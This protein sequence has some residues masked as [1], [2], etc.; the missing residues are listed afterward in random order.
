MRF[1]YNISIWLYFF[2]ITV[3]SLFNDKA[4]LW[5]KGRKGIFDKIKIS[6][7]GNDNIIWFHCSSLGEF[8]QGRPLLE[9][10]KSEYPK[11][12]ILLTFFSPSGYEIRKNYEKTDYIFYLP[13]DTIS[14]AKKFVEL[15][16]P[17]I[18]VF[19]KY[20]F[21]FNYISEL[22]K[23]NI[24]IYSVSS[25]FRKNQYFFK[26]HGIWALQQ[27]K[28]IS[29]FFVQ[30]EKS[31]ELLGTL[32]IINVIV[33]GDTRF[34]RVYE[35]S[36]NVKKFPVIEAFRQNKKIL[37]AGSIWQKEE[38]FLIKLINE[39][40]F[41]IKYIIAP[42]LIKT[43]NIDNFISKI[44]LKA[45]KFSEATTENVVAPKVMLIDGIGFLSHLYQ[46]GTLALIGGGFG[47]GIHNI[48]EPATFGLPVFFGPNYTKFN[49]AKELLKCGG[50]YSI[51]DFQNLNEKLSCLLNNEEALKRNSYICL[52][53]VDNRKGAT[54]I[55]LKYIEKNI[56][57]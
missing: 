42:H 2:A 48:L 33:S 37:I 8:E 38:E 15:V 13:L 47:K 52:N 41:D 3:A 9:K 31:K 56:K 46:Y 30:D 34:D 40:E 24:P 4:K 57:F 55:I 5:L 32:G 50:A 35:I 39:S 29:C 27:L 22:H 53:Y 10:I 23:R 7:T 14:N 54:D 20:E 45:I 44:S 49:E 16:N 18:A 6:L 1:I 43:E 17:Q 28:K 19:V 25:I 26:I 12:K 51:T 36:K 21:W 11:Y